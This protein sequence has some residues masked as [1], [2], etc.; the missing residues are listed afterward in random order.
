M[1]VGDQI[2]HVERHKDLNHLGD[3]QAVREG[4]G[5]REQRLALPL[6]WGTEA[7]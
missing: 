6:V 5:K 7:A 1:S 2:G 4:R 3:K